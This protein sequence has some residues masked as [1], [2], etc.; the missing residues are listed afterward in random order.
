MSL[1]HLQ[2]KKPASVGKEIF[3]TAGRMRR[4]LPVALL[5]LVFR[6]LP[7]GSNSSWRSKLFDH[8]SNDR[9]P[10]CR[11]RRFRHDKDG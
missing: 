3:R 7:A 6:R 8:C 2:F 1:Y 10:Q 11:S 9:D 4:F 5:A